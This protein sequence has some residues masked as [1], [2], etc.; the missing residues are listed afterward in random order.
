MVN[1]LQIKDETGEKGLLEV[2]KELA[3]YIR[4]RA[5]AVH[6]HRTVHKYYVEEAG[7][8][9]RLITQFNKEHIQGGVGHRLP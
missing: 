7:I 4:N 9:K 5:K 1:N 8:V 6:I 3:E 2:S